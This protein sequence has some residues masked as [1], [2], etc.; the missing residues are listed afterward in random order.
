MI[1]KNFKFIF[2]GNSIISCRY[3]RKRDIN[4]VVQTVGILYKSIIYH[5]FIRR[6]FDMLLREKHEPAISV[7]S[8]IIF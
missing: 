7:N 5:Y 8:V 6:K 1:A 3:R 4:T 2:R